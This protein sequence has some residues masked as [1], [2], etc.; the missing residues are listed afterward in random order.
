[1]KKKDFDCVEMKSRI[2]ADLLKRTEGMSFEEEQRFS[3]KQISSNPILARF[4]ARRRPA[5]ATPS[6][7]KERTA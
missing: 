4:W 2:Q 1:M 3:D 7:A 6:S 5:G